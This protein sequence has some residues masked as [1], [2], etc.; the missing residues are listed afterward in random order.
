MFTPDVG[1]NILAPCL[2]EPS[3]NGPKVVSPTVAPRSLGPILERGAASTPWTP[4]ASRSATLRAGRRDGSWRITVRVN[5]QNC[6]VVEEGKI[7]K[8]KPLVRAK[9]V[10][11]KIRREFL[12]WFEDFERTELPPGLLILDMQRGAWLSFHLAAPPV[13]GFSRSPP[14]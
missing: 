1:F 7:F 12:C 5:L 14:I 3:A 6:S 8:V 9:T 10:G 4:S 2:R 13:L 11:F